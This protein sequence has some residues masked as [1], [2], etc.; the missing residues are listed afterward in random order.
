MGVARYIRHRLR[1]ID[2]PR[3]GTG[4]EMRWP[5]FPKN[6]NFSTYQRFTGKRVLKL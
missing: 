1:P 5:K 6:L 3:H 4:L 2:V